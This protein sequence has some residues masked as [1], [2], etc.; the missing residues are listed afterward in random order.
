MSKRKEG[1]T[2]TVERALTFSLEQTLA[3]IQ[4]STD[5]NYIE[6]LRRAVAVINQLCNLEI[7]TLVLLAEKLT[8]DGK[9]EAGREGY[10]DA[11]RTAA[12]FG[13]IDRAIELYKMAE[14]PV[15]AS[16][17]SRKVTQRH[18]METPGALDAYIKN[19]IGRGRYGEAA[20]ELKKLVEEGVRRFIFQPR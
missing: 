10:E 3:G 11:A 17:L 15:K 8:K 13:Y 2:T 18:Y 16:E 14:M 4:D 9:K 7:G 6:N 19:C 1:R 12:R 5:P 20:S